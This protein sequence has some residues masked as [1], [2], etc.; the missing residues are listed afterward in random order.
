MAGA[1]CKVLAIRYFFIK[2][3]QINNHRRISHNFFE[4]IP[5]LSIFEAY[6]FEDNYERM[7]KRLNHH[8]FLSPKVK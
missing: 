4:N 6:D 5:S 7:H 3:D 2:K 8:N 1:A